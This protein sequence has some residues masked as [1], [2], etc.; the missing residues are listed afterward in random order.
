MFDPN[1]QLKREILD[2]LQDLDWSRR[3]SV[4]SAHVRCGNRSCRCRAE[5]PQLHGPYWQWTWKAQGKTVTRRLQ[6]QQVDLV[7]QWISNSHQLD[8]LLAQFDQ[9]SVSV[10]D[11]ILARLSANPT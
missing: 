9:L 3:G 8:L 5:P 2:Q 10:T 11:A 6:P 1:Q 4:L 7:R